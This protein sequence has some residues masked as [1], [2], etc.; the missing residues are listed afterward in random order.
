MPWSLGAK[1]LIKM[2]KKT[3]S[4]IG[5]RGYPSFYGGFETAVRKL[6]PF[7]ADQ[8]WQV[9][10]YSRVGAYQPDHPTRDYRVEIRESRGL[11]S[12]KL[13]TLSHGLF[14]AINICRNRTDV[15]IV[16]NVANG[17]WLP[18]IRL[19]G[20]K[21]ILNVDGIEWER[22]KWSSLGKQ[23]F[24]LGAKMSA[25][26]SDELVFDALA[27]GDY[28]QK[29]YGVTGT[30]IPYGGEEISGLGP[31]LQLKRRGYVLLVAR[32][33]PENSI[34]EF[35]EAVKIMANELFVVIVGSS[36][37]N[38]EFD[39]NANKLA[40]DY[41]KVTYLGHVKDDQL[42]FSLFENCGAYFHGHSVGG[43]NPALVQAM[44]CGAPVIA[45]DTVYN[46]EVLGPAAFAFVSPDP[47]EIA[48]SIMRLMRDAVAQE[49]FSVEAKNRAIINYRWIDVCSKY[50]ELASTLCAGKNPID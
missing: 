32:F 5:T 42:L 25:R 16:M 43:T 15:V 40:D 45:R 49:T 23:V 22:D 13:S 34:A 39:L 46:R 21:V 20:V 12:S 28:W 10:V 3:I 50:E 24:K 9:S 11:N 48:Q 8:G 4:I 31:P 33:V 30:F 38:G 19:F 6:A 35:F 17:F 37:G 7:L 41:D 29:N 18:L 27:I 2:P 47:H 1:V 36:G 26:Y 44:H 14:S